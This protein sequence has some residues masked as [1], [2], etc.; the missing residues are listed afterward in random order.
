MYNRFILEL[1][2]EQT[3][4]FDDKVLEICTE[5][6]FEEI[7][8]HDRG[9]GDGDGDTDTATA[10]KDQFNCFKRFRKVLVE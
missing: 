2:P 1:R 5:A 8:L 6:G 10:L 9:I 3:K 4:V 7:R